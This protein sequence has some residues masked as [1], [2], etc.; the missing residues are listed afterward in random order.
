MAHAVEDVTEDSRLEAED[1]FNTPAGAAIQSRVFDVLE[2]AVL[3]AYGDLEV[4]L[5]LLSRY[6]VTP[7]CYRVSQQVAR[8]ER[9]NVA[10]L[11]DLCARGFRST[12]NLCAETPEGDAPDLRKAGLL[13]AMAT[14]RFPVEDN[15]EPQISQV[16]DFLDYALDPANA[17]TYVH[18]EAGKGRTGVMIACYRMAVMGW[19]CHDALTEAKNFGCSVP[20]QEAFIQEFGRFLEAR[21]LGSLDSGDPSSPLPSTYP[22]LR[23]GSIGATSEEL[24]ATLDGAA[25]SGGCQME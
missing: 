2:N 19:D 15:H 24:A 17:P 11:R 7:Y 4:P 16:G 21:R 10:K 6:P 22:V 20:A 5:E 23:F 1:I 3:G 8:G 12:V 18:C 13:D 25:R 9:P 14:T